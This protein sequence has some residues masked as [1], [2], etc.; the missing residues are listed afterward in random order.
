MLKIFTLCLLSVCASALEVEIDENKV[1]FGARIDLDSGWINSNGY[2]YQKS[3]IRRARIHVVGEIGD[4]YAY[5]IEHAFAGRNNWT[6][7]YLKYIGFDNWE[8]YAGN[9][10]QP[11]G[12]EATT[13]SRHTTFIERALA[14][15]SNPRKLGLMGRRVHFNNDKVYTFALSVFDKSLDNLIN[16]EKYGTSVVGRTTYANIG[17]ESDILHFGLALAQTSYD[18]NYINF[19]TDAGSNLYD[20]SFI[21]TT[22]KDIENSTRIGLELAL[23]SGAFSFQGEYIAFL[24]R[25]KQNTYNLNG[26]YTQISWF[27]TGESRQYRQSTATF[28]QIQ[29]NN[30]VNNGGMGALE[31]ALRATR[32]DLSDYGNSNEDEYGIGLE[33]NWYLMPNLRLMT[34]YTYTN[35]LKDSTDYAKVFQFRIQYD[36]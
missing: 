3:D 36:F 16:N 19:E 22:I 21:E 26:W 27:A 20:G 13:S 32:I 28:T 17:Q 15:F 11:F 14:E 10:W 4:S 35:M 23:V 7:V 2:S 25:K 29:P 34:N 6:D 1:K 12:L 33:V 24:A 30:P 31:L 9:M 8:I 18:K 5:E